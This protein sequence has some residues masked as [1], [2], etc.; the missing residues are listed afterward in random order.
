MKEEIGHFDALLKDLWVPWSFSRFLHWMP[1]QVECE[2]RNRSA[3]S[4]FFFLTFQPY[5]SILINFIYPKYLQEICA[6]MVRLLQL[7]NH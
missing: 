5:F 6:I 3:Q 4:F 7:V 2:S 1:C